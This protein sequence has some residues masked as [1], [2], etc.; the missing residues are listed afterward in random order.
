MIKDIKNLF[1]TYNQMADEEFKSYIKT[2]DV[3]DSQYHNG[4]YTAFAEAAHMLAE[5]LTSNNP[6]S[7][8]Q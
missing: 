6:D 7:V 3:E 8:S 2:R 5:V 4:R 1:D